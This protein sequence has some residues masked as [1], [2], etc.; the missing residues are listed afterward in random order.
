M[1]D[2]SA[3]RPF[4]ETAD[5][6]RAADQPPASRAPVIILAVIG[7]VLHF[8]LQAVSGEPADLQPAE[9]TGA[10]TFTALSIFV[11]ALILAGLGALMLIGSA[12]RRY[13]QRTW[14]EDFGWLFC[15]AL[16]G[17]GLGLGLS[18]ALTALGA[19]PAG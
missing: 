17:G 14:G 11:F 13:R 10:I 16:L 6:V 8:L 5:R 15:A 2:P 12:A 7:L 19:P 18:M 4:F 9:R 3:E 1:N